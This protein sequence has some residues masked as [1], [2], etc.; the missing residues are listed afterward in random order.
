LHQVYPQL[1]VPA[2]AGKI[3]IAAIRLISIAFS[4]EV[5]AASREENASKQESGASVLIEPE[6]K[7]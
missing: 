1:A 5:D 4:S 2:R 6:L 3:R 7:L